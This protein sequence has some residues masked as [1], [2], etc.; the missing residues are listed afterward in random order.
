MV[1]QSHTFF[2]LPFCFFSGNLSLLCSFSSLCSCRSRFSC[3]LFCLLDS[4][5]LINLSTTERESWKIISC[6]LKFLR[7]SD[8]SCSSLLKLRIWKTTNHTSLAALLRC[9][10]PPVC[11][12]FS[13]S[14]FFFSYACSCF[15]SSSKAAW[16]SSAAA[17]DAAAA[18]SAAAA[19]ALA[20]S[21]TIRKIN[22][23]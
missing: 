16:H 5:S 1:N 13:K 22:T 11:E 17:R 8:L 14:D 21:W 3:S 20:A 9:T 18:F 15:F 6:M 23:N 7:S 19:V 4:S 12:A 2:L 10:T